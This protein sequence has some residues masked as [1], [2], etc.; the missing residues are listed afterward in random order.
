MS[1][2]AYLAAPERRRRILEC[3]KHVFARRGYHDTNI[4]HIC[5]AMGIARGTLYQYFT[6]KKDVFA[7]IVE[8]MLD[9]RSRRRRARAGR[10]HPA[11]LP[12]DARSRCSSTRRPA[13]SASSRRSSPTRRACRILVREAVGLDVG[14]DAI[15]HAIDALVDRPVRERPRSGARRGDHSRR[16]RARARRPSSSW[17]A[18][19]SWRS[20][21]SGKRAEPT[22]RSTSAR[23]RPGS[24][25]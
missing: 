20:T 24:R 12:S 10:A 9:A 18:S 23:S 3:A 15:L 4:S 2:A 21:R 22:T 14:I 6:S 5:E 19:R 8:E 7:A 1:Y 25:A 17:A 16:R 13:C 11:G